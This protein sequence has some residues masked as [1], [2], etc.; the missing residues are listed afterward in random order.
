MEQTVAG[1]IRHHAAARRD[2][3]ALVFG[4]RRITYGEL[5]RHASQVAQGLL[6]EGLAPQARVAVLDKNSDGFFEILFGAAKARAVLVAVNWRLASPEVAYVLNDA[7]AEILF[8]G[9]EFLPVVGKIRD[10]LGSVR[11]V[12]ALAEAEPAV[13]AAAELARWE[14]YPAWRNRQRERDPQLPIPAD[15]VALQMYTSGT[16]GHP[17]GAQLTHA[18]LLSHFPVAIREWGRPWTPEEVVLVCMPIFHIGGSGWALVGFYAGTRVVVVR[19]VL[20]GEIL[21][22]IPVER[23]TKALFVPAVMQLLLQTPG[24]AETDFSSLDLILYGASP[25]P[26]D[27]LRASLA[28]FRCQLGQGYGLTETTGAVTYLPPADHTPEGSPRMRS[29]GRPLPTAEI[30][31][32]APDGT[33]LPPGEIGEI[34]C[35]SPQVMKGYWNLPEE[36]ARVI[37]GGW[38]HTGDAGYLDADGYLYIHDRVKDMI[39]SG[40]ENVYP[41]EVEHA[42]FAHPAVAD[43]AVIG[44][45]DPRWG[46]AVKAIVVRKPGMD[47]S[48]EEL[49]AFARDRIAGY[50]VPKSVD[51]VDALPRNPSG[52]V[53]K[54]LLRAPYWQDHDRQVS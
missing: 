3:D 30:R 6:A 23:V 20:P 39:V 46:E 33:P 15:D 34:V 11:R 37:R 35:L 26:L 38:L 45:P 50:K 42:L 49:V 32:V 48:A 13:P 29:C 24:C 28:T 1:I 21:R 2:H 41:A 44:V 47:A 51:F 54:R 36:T 40:G 25:I 53:L 5:D 17:K 31:I 7:G 14:R 4:K 12:I 43:V 10:E 27:L 16:T 52:K 22:V 9:P 19:E 8:V 18:N